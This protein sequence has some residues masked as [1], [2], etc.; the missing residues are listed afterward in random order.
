MNNR[1]FIKSEFLKCTFIY[2]FIYIIHGFLKFF[3]CLFSRIHPEVLRAFF[4][5]CAQESRLVASGDH[6][7]CQGWNPSQPH[8]GRIFNPLYYIALA[9]IYAF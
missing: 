6:K 1:Y 8:A 3:V 9:P 4:W 5:P 2:I 7:G